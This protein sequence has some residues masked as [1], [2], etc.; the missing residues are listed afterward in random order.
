[1]AAELEVNVVKEKVL[2]IYRKTV[3]SY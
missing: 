3:H 1:V 2:T